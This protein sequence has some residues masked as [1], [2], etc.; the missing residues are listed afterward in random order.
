MSRGRSVWGA[1]VR[2][3]HRDERVIPISYDIPDREPECPCAGLVR[4][5]LF[6]RV[7]DRDL[8]F[9]RRDR[10]VHTCACGGVFARPDGSV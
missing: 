4:S 9:F 1:L 2:I 8:P 3:L 7:P 6:V 10:V 5:H